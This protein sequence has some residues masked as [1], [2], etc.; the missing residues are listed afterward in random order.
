MASTWISSTYDSTSFTWDW[1]RLQAYQDGNGHVRTLTYDRLPD[2]TRSLASLEDAL[3][4]VYTIAYDGERS[5][6]RSRSTR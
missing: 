3:G 2:R 6:A 1:H 4:G 5:D